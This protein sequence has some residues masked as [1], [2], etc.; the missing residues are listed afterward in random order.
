MTPLLSVIVGMCS[1]LRKMNPK[2]NRPLQNLLL[3]GRVA[4]YTVRGLCYLAMYMSLAAATAGVACAVWM[5][6]WTGLGR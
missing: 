6:V 5:L 3:A 2:T 1:G 4:Y